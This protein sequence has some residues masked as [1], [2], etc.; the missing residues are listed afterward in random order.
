MKKNIKKIQKTIDGVSTEA[1]NAAISS[2]VGLCVGVPLGP[3]VGG[4][5]GA[6]SS[7]LFR[8]I[9]SRVNGDFKTRF[10]SE[11]E[12]ERINKTAE[13]VIARIQLNF[14]QG[15]Q[16]RNDEFF[17]EESLPDRSTAYEIFEGTYIAAKNEHE[18]KKLKYYGNLI[19]NIAFRPEIDRYHANYLLRIVERLSYR[20]ICILALFNRKSSYHISSNREL[21]KIL[22]QNE[23]VIF[24]EIAE[25]KILNLLTSTNEYLMGSS[26]GGN[27]TP[28]TTELSETG[29]IMNRLMNLDEIEKSEVDRLA[30]ILSDPV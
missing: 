30:G 21:E 17:S 4:A 8:E 29:K 28:A 3:I 27:I 11:W 1:A 18:E 25:M 13:A 22:N 23:K 7:K 10:L 6:I 19:A 14:S 9:I 15:F 26:I 20:Q 24:R 12:R 2:S 16:F 5:A